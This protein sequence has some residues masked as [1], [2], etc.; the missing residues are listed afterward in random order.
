MQPMECNRDAIILYLIASRFQ[1]PNNPGKPS[2]QEQLL[3][4]KSMETGRIL[5]RAEGTAAGY[6]YTK[7]Q[8]AADTKQL[9][10]LILNAVMAQDRRWEALTKARSV[11]ANLAKGTAIEAANAAI[12]QETDLNNEIEAANEKIIRW[13]AALARIQPPP[14]S[15]SKGAPATNPP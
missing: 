6:T 2:E 11:T 9:N 15:K 8:K 3:I 12:K 5:A 4:A 1:S 14:T 7:E 13:K 10:V